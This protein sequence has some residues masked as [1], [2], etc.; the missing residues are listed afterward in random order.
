MEESSQA[1]PGE[2]GPAVQ[3]EKELSNASSSSTTNPVS[4]IK[5]DLIFVDA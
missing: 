4:Q 5:Q 2:P 1:K 3:A